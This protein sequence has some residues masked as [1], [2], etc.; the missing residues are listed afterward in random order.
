MAKLTPG[1][2]M[3]KC[4]CCGKRTHSS[5]GNM[6]D[7]RL[8]GVCIASAEQENAHVDGTPHGAADKKTCPRCAGVTCLHVLYPLLAGGV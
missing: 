2:V 1:N 5:L 8:C 6:S 3:C 7:I 4:E